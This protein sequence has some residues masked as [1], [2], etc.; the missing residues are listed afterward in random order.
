MAGILIYICGSNIHKTDFKPKCVF[1]KSSID[2]MPVWR[3]LD[4]R[5]LRCHTVLLLTGDTALHLPFSCDLLNTLSKQSRFQSHFG[6][7]ISSCNYLKTLW[8]ANYHAN[9]FALHICHHVVPLNREPKPLFTPCKCTGWLGNKWAKLEECTNIFLTS[10]RIN[11]FSDWKMYLI[12][13]LTDVHCS[14]PQCLYFCC[15][16]YSISL[17]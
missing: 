13:P 16:F 6:S 15:Q 4:W 9:Y 14:L 8:F 2:T 7:A 11:I 1:I 17:H 12:A 10:L 3:W 5:G